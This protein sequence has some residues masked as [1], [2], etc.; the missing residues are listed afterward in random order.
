M[1]SILQRHCPGFELF[2]VET[3]GVQVSDICLFTSNP[4]VNGRYD[5]VLSVGNNNPFSAAEVSSISVFGD[6]KEESPDIIM[7]VSGWN[8]VSACEIASYGTQD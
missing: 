7:I 2:Q 4:L 6:G 5:F 3:V 1:G 8:A